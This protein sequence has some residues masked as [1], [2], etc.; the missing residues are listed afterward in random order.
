MVGKSKP[1]KYPVRLL[2]DHC[3]FMCLYKGN[4]QFYS[5]SEMVNNM[6]I[7]QGDFKNPFYEKLGSEPAVLHVAATITTIK[8]TDN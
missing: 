1:V 3:L 4:T 8:T 6:F 7:C 2:L 5:I